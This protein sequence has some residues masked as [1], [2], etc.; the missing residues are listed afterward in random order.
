MGRVKDYNTFLKE[1]ELLSNVAS[2]K[3]TRLL[4]PNYRSN[5]STKNKDQIEAS[6]DKDG[7]KGK[8]STTFEFKDDIGGFVGKSPIFSGDVTLKEIDDDGSVSRRY[9]VTS[10]NNKGESGSFTWGGEVEDSEGIIVKNPIF[11][12]PSGKKWADILGPDEDFLKTFVNHGHRWEINI[13]EIEGVKLVKAGLKGIYEIEYD[14]K[15]QFYGKVRIYYLGNTGSSFFNSYYS[16]EVKD[17]PNKGA[18][19]TGFQIFR[20]GENSEKPGVYNPF[21]DGE[22]ILNVIKYPAISFSKD[23]DSITANTIAG[24]GINPNQVIFFNT[25]EDDTINPPTPKDF[26][27]MYNKNF[28]AGEIKDYTESSITGADSTSALSSVGLAS[29]RWSNIGNNGPILGKVK[30]SEL[31]GNKK[32]WINSVDGK[33][34]YL[35]LE[36]FPKIANSSVNECYVAYY[37]GN[38]LLLYTVKCEKR[39]S[40]SLDWNKESGTYGNN[41]FVGMIYNKDT[42]KWESAKGEWYFD[43]DKDSQLN[44]GKGGVGIIYAYRSNKKEINH[45]VNFERDITPSKKK[46]IPVKGKGSTP[47]VG[48]AGDYFMF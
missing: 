7:K 5:I 16:Y 31:S 44:N 20:V 46:E 48:D 30:K 36:S 33:T 25:S 10:G 34:K 9:E 18:K 35:T 45:I 15:F 4:D 19:G 42:Q 6:F 47:E 24:S 27:E 32:V 28:I 1:N 14:D 8:I 22:T 29:L 37:L 26:L 21:S 38:P 13:S 39:N 40:P 41:F 17:G 3:M 43:Y 11:E 12:V 2:K 23:K